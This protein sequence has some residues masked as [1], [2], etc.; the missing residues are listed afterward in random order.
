MILGF[1][2]PHLTDDAFEMAESFLVQC[3]KPSTYLETFDELRVA[4]FDNNALKID[5]SK[6]LHALQQ[7]SGNTSK[8]ATAK[9]S[10]GSKPR[11]G[12]LLY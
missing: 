7:I 12:M 5:F 6:E 1:D 11:S 2:G 8:E 9:Y 4:V 3:L 10:Y